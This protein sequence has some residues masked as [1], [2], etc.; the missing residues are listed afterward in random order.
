MLRAFSPDRT[1]DLPPRPLPA[2]YWVLPGRLL[3]GE[4]PGSRSRAE[5]MDRLG[6]AANAL[7]SRLGLAVFDAWRPLAL[8]AELYDASLQWRPRTDSNRRRRP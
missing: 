6:H 1:R 5:A 2:S 4:Y 3:V 8:Q 7:P